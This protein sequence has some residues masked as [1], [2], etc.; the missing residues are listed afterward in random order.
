MILFV[1][2]FI[3]GFLVLSTEL[4]FA[5]NVVGSTIR[6]GKIMNNLPYFARPFKNNISVGDEVWF[7]LLECIMTVISI[8]VDNSGQPLFELKSHYTNEFYF[9]RFGEI[10]EIW[11]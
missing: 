1:V 7:P 11:K 10:Y 9:A 3:L 5:L 6:L 2:D 8:T 4:M